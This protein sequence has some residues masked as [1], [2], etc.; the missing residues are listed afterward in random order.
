MHE[1]ILEPQFAPEPGHELVPILGESDADREARLAV[2]AE[3]RA[4]AQRERDEARRRREAKEAER[5]RLA[6]EDKA[7][8]DAEKR[9]REEE[10]KR[11]MADERAAKEKA[12]AEAGAERRRRSVVTKDGAWLDAGAIDGLNGPQSYMDWSDR[13]EDHKQAKGQRAAW[14]PG[15]AS[16]M[17]ERR[18]EDRGGT[19]KSPTRVKEFSFHTAKR[20]EKRSDTNRQ[21]HSMP[22]AATE[23]GT[24]DWEAE[25]TY[26]QLGY[27][28]SGEGQQPRP[29]IAMLL[30]MG[31][32]PAEVRAELRRAHQSRHATVMVQAHVRGH[33]A[34]TEFDD[35]RRASIM[36]QT[37]IRGYAART[38]IEEQRT[39]SV[40]VQSA[41]R[42]LSAQQDYKQQ[43]KAAVL[44]QAHMR[45]LAAK[46]EFDQQRKAAVL[47]QAHAR[48][49]MSP[50][51][52]LSRGLPEPMYSAQ[53]PFGQPQ[54]LLSPLTNAASS[55]SWTAAHHGTG[56]RPGS[57]AP[58]AATRRSPHAIDA[59]PWHAMMSSWEPDM[60][61]RSVMIRLDR[62]AK[63]EGSMRG[64]SI[65]R[66]MAQHW[67]YVPPDWSTVSSEEQPRLSLPKHLHKL[68]PMAT[69]Y[70]TSVRLSPQPDGDRQVRLR[71]AAPLPPQLNAVQRFPARRSTS[72]PIL[73]RRKDV[74]DDSTVDRP[75]GSPVPIL[76]FNKKQ[77]PGRPKIMSGMQWVEDMANS[78]AHSR[79]ASMSS[80]HGTS[81]APPLPPSPSRSRLGQSPS[82]PALRA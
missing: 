2:E 51:L 72:L 79:P 76:R 61:A 74:S 52:P 81:I 77:Q 58:S 80:L 13:D 34:K 37:Q 73:V 3:L 41:F 47:I 4:A 56:L 15:G 60:T 25:L 48:R 32:T 5:Q 75:R 36:M 68:P 38:S 14:R 28:N 50:T 11:R 69:E 67:Q 6:V 12:L 63:L 31:L 40:K 39:A 66:H 45:R 70:G 55:L 22:G 59:T 54:Y 9:R 57:L 23:G 1:P 10:L 62:G 19:E 42:G 65:L 30:S 26:L 53:Q 7:E 27:P 64:M 16:T 71:R 20:A 17:D 24:P 33:A 78:I 46:T 35:K 18:V 21:R 29:E 44:V 82:L 43:R 8:A 49:V